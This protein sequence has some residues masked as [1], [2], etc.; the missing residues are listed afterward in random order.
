MIV[1][2]RRARRVPVERLS[3]RRGDEAGD[4]TRG[5]AIF[6]ER[7][8]NC[9]LTSFSLFRK[10]GTLELASGT[11][12]D[13]LFGFSCVCLVDRF[14]PVR[15][16]FDREHDR[17]GNERMR[18]SLPVS[19]SVFPLGFFS[20]ACDYARLRR[21][22]GDR[23]EGWVVCRDGIAGAPLIYPFTHPCRRPGSCKGAPTLLAVRATGRG[24]SFSLLFAA[25]LGLYI[26]YLPP[27]SPYLLPSFSSSYTASRISAY[28]SLSFFLTLA[29]FCLILA[30]SPISS[31]LSVPDHEVPS[32]HLV[33]RARFI[34]IFGNG[35]AIWLVLLTQWDHPFNCKHC[36]V[37]FVRSK[38]FAIND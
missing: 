9:V 20:R 32:L 19:F 11:A 38:N 7:D 23:D 3:F 12:V 24:L 22:V 31:L 15:A 5:M 2:S 10:R 1:D 36:T 4:E 27:C 25:L 14:S 35:F 37:C 34:E 8:R 18:G 29:R 28:L 33:P 30:C 16:N 13:L 6:C 26:P 21:T 17:S